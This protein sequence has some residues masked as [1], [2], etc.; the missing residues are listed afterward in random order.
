MTAWT[1]TTSN[2]TLLMRA[3]LTSI[4]H[5]RVAS[6]VI[7]I[8]TRPDP[9]LHRVMVARFPTLPLFVVERLDSKLRQFL[10]RRSNSLD[11]QPVLSNNTS[12]LSFSTVDDIERFLSKT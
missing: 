3:P 4:G 1:G 8:V 2:A 10:L 6:E 9:L 7:V 11:W 12:A 5:T